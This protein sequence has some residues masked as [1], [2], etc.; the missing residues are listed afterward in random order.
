VVVVL[1]LIHLLQFDG[2]YGQDSYAYLEQCNQFKAHAINSNFYPPFY[3]ICGWLVQFL[4]G[5][6][7]YS[8]QLISLL[9]IVLS[10][11]LLYKIIEQVHPIANSLNGYLWVVFLGSPFI[12]RSSI[13]V[14]S[15]AL[16][17]FLVTAMLWLIVSQVRFAFF[18]GSLVFTAAV[19]TRYA[20]FPLLAPLLL[21]IFITHL[22]QRAWAQIVLG[23]FSMGIIFVLNFFLFS[24]ETGSIRHEWLQT[25]SPAHFFNR[26]FSTIDGYQSYFAPNILYPLKLFVH[27]GFFPTFFILVWFVR[28]IDF[29]KTMIQWMV[30]S[31]MIYF[32]FLSGIPFQ[33]ERFLMIAFPMVVVLMFPAFQRFYSWLRFRMI[34]VGLLFLSEILL[35]ARAVKPFYD[36]IRFEKALVTIMTPYQHKTLYAFDA[37]V[38][39]KG[40]GLQFNYQNLWVKRYSSFDSGALVLFNEEKFANQWQN[41][42]PMLNFQLMKDT[43]NLQ[44]ELNLGNSWMLYSIKGRNE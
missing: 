31:M 5:N 11:I 19:L 10:A 24:S 7:A 38:A 12:F 41:K 39:L 6:C 14:M 4:I 1:T 8:L 42:N 21:Y 16:C 23:L 22:K 2:A 26:S 30:F 13:L 40:R 44:T 34:S 43:Y 35:T 9:S 3:A 20:A 36:R 32:I 33:N 18:Y 37:D 27:P 25:W 29:S 17:L 28:K 15:D